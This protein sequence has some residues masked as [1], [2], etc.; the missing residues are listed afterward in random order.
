MPESTFGNIVALAIKLKEYDW[1]ILF[2][3][4]YQNQL[5]PAFQQPLFHFSKAKLLYEQKELEE[6]MRE[7]SLV[8]TKAPFLFLGARTLQLKI[9]YELGEIDLL[10]S[11]LESLRVYLQRRKDLGYRRQNYDN[12]IVFTRQLLQLPLLS[13]QEKIELKK[14]VE[15]AEIFTEREWCIKQINS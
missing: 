1:A 10:E 9:Y 3:E 13:K 8:E 11:L 15:Q 6:S 7:I 4:Q 12:L 2:L 14:R 5:K